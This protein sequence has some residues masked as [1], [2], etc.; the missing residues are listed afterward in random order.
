M[1]LAGIIFLI[2][3]TV[4]AAMFSILFKIFH[5]K[6]VD[7]GQAI[8]FNYLTA[9]VIGGLFSLHGELAVNPLK[10]HWLYGRHDTTVRLHTPCWSSHI[11][12]LQ[13]CIYGYPHY[14]VIPYD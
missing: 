2:I 12:S 7:S 6:G 10:A 8:F 3:A 14:S 5:V 11:N 1:S 4:C 13:P 9:F